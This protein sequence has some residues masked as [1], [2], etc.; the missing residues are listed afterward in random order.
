MNK[1]NHVAHD[2]FVIYYFIKTNVLQILL[3]V[4]IFMTQGG[5]KIHHKLHDQ[6]L[7]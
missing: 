2:I 5:Y 6:Y 7:Q 1:I 3:Y 4:V